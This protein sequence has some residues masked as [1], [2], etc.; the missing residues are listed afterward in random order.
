MVSEVSHELGATA[1]RSILTGALSLLNLGLLFW[2]SAKLAAVGVLF[3][4]L[5]AAVT[6]AT[7]VF[8]RA[9][10]RALELLRGKLFGF[11]VQAI[12][13]VGKLRA[14]GAEKRSFARWARRYA[15]Q[16]RLTVS[17]QRWEDADKLL[18]VL[19]GALATAGLYALAARTLL[20]SAAAGGTPALS[21]G[22]FLAFMAA[23]GAL[24]AGLATLGHAVVEVVDQAARQK[25]A[26]PILEE[27]PESSPGRADPGRLA[28]HVAVAGV[29]FHY[30][31]GGPA[32]V[33]G[34]T[35][36][37]RPGEF[38]AVVGPS[39]SGKSTLLRLLLG[40]ERPESGAVFFDGKDIGGL[41]LPALR[42]QLGTVLQS[43]RVVSGTLFDNIAGGHLVG[44]EEV[45]AAVRDAG[46]ADDLA[47]LPMGLHTIISEGGANLSGGQRQRLLLARAMVLN[48]R[49]VILD[50]ATSALDSRLQA[51]V[52]RSLGRRRVTRVVVAHRLSTVQNADRIYVMDAGEVVQVGTFAELLRQGGLFGRLALGQG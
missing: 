19:L 27:K 48:P 24:S 37:A 5:S 23:F 45:L 2:Y 43:A 1:L 12:E 47:E 49:V 17:V 22:S 34:V 32:V 9:R 20:T 26:S 41:D 35:V 31:P 14:A 13:G 44:Q 16:L 6:A 18:Q 39:G 11:V 38:V 40:F 10:A 50:E 51:H 8:V 3:A 25:L 30:Q 42:R 52:T 46:L 29:T 28:G 15:E 21:L 7:A 33:K 36:E 4:L